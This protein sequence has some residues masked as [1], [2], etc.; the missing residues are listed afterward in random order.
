VEL[1]SPPAVILVF[2]V[3]L[4]LFGW[5]LLTRSQGLQDKKEDQS[6]QLSLF[7]QQQ[8]AQLRKAS[9]AEIQACRISLV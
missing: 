1:L 3:G 7:M 8:I 6:D 4:V 5:L 9:V 2:S